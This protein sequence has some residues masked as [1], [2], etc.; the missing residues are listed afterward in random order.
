MP[1]SKSLVRRLIWQKD[2]PATF[3]ADDVLLRDSRFSKPIR[4]CTFGKSTQAE[5]Q[6][7]V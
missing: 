7:S 5:V 6:V 4:P 2:G 3:D 1:L